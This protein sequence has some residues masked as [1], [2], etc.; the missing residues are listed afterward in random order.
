MEAGF[1]TL[2]GTAVKLTA[3][4]VENLKYDPA[5]GPQQSVKDDDTRGLYL[6]LYRDSKVWTYR[7]QMDHK[8][9]VLRLGTYPV[10]TL[11]E[12]RA[13]AAAAKTKV[14]EGTDPAAAAREAART[15]KEAAMRAEAEA[16]RMPTVEGFAAAYIERY[17][18]P[19]K[20]SW[21]EDERLLRHDVIPVLGAMKLDQVH[22]RDIIA[23]LDGIRDRGKSVLANRVLAVTRRMFNFAIERGV[24]E[25]SPVLRVKASPEA[26]RERILSD[27]EICGLW[28]ATGE[29]SRMAPAT[30]LALRVLLLTGQREDEVCGME[31]SEVDLQDGLWTIP[32]SR[33]KNKMTHTVPLAPRPWRS[34]RKP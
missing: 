34:S 4:T 1:R 24:L 7:F 27:G 10:M 8:T 22:R 28:E 20:R 19:N 3:K 15:A 26:P 32:G 29:G 11:A 13:A 5:K 33:V 6:R 16:D 12:A 18:K 9:S 25:H 17:A 30:R 14:D 23:L 31:R 2:R 21:A